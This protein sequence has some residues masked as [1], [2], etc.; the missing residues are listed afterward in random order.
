MVLA[1]PHRHVATQRHAVVAGQLRQFVIRHAVAEAENHP[2]HAFGGENVGVFEIGDFRRRAATS[3]AIAGVHQNLGRVDHALVPGQF[4]E[5]IHDI[6]RQVHRMA[7]VGLFGVGVILPAD[8]ADGHLRAD[9]LAG[10]DVAQQAAFV[11]RLVQ[12]R[13]GLKPFRADFAGFDTRADRHIALALVA[14]QQQRRPIGGHDQQGLFKTRVEPGQIGQIGK[15]LPI[16]IDDQMGES[17]AAHGSPSGGESF[18]EL[19]GRCPWRR[20]GLAKLGPI[21][22]GNT[23][24][25]DF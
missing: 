11:A 24:S 23:M 18:L 3:Q 5:R 2:P 19:S 20:L 15:M 4:A 17:M 8:A 14:D 16:G 12:Q 25:H 6:G 13:E 9:A 21:N 10:E 7:S 22:L 1:R